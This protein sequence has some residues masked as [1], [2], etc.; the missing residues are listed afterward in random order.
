MLFGNT[1]E[2]ADVT[3][4][5]Q[6]THQEASGTETPGHVGCLYWLQTIQNPDE[7]PSA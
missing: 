1:I 4:E 6:K 5:M 2:D 7:I 3:G